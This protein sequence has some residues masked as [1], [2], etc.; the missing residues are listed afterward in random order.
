MECT[1][2]RNV[3]ER[4]YGW[5]PFLYTDSYFVYLF[6]LALSWNLVALWPQLYMFCTYFLCVIFQL[7]ATSSR[8]N[9]EKPNTNNLQMS[10]TPKPLTDAAMPNVMYIV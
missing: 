2:D 6:F 3:S 4:N 7:K 8:S 1:S 9:T 10:M 5:K